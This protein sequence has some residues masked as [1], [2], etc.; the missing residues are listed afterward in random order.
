MNDAHELLDAAETWGA[1]TVVP[2]AGGGAP[3]HWEIGLGPPLDGT[4]PVYRSVDPEPEVVATAA[5]ERSASRQLGVV[6]SPVQVCIL[7]PGDGAVL[8]EDGARASVRSSWPYQGDDHA[9]AALSSIPSFCVRYASEDWSA[10]RNDET[11]STGDSVAWLK[12]KAL[13]GLL[14]REQARRFGLFPPTS[15]VQATSDNFRRRFG[16]GAI[17]DMGQFF[18]QQ[19]LDSATWKEMMTDICAIE[20]LEQVLHPALLARVPAVFRVWNARAWQRS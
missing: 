14:A 9:G 13:L 15:A 5:A 6:P 16:L 10:R 17:A 2:Y 11:T 1:K 12:K 7:R 18:A 19:G 8:N 3:W 4:G 20:T